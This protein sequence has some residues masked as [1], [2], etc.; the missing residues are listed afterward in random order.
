MR[1]RVRRKN[2]KQYYFVSFIVF[3]LLL[4]LGYSI[5]TTNLNIT[6]T[7]VLKDNRWDIHFENVQLKSGSVGST[8]T[9]DSN[10][11]SVS[12]SITLNKPGDFYEFTVDAVND[13]TID[14]M[15]S[16]VSSKLNGNPIT[17]LPTA[18]NYTLTYFDGVEIQNNHLLSAET[19]EIYKIRVEYRTDIEGDDL[20]DEEQ[21]LN[22]TFSANFV[23]A[24]DTAVEVQHR[25]L[26]DVLKNEALNGGLAKEYVGNHKD[27][28]NV[29]ATK[30]IYHWYADN[31]TDGIQVTNMSNVIFGGFCWQMLRTTDTGGVKLIYNGVPAN[32][33]CNN[34]GT[35]QI[36]GTSSFNSSDN[37]LY[38]VGYRYNTLASSYKEKGNSAATSGSLFG[39]GVTYSGSTYTLTDTST[40]YDDY[41]HYT[42]NNTTGTCSTVRYYHYN[43]YYIELTSGRTVEYALSEML[44]SDRTNISNSTIKRNVDSWYSS[45]LRN[46]ASQLEDT[47]FC[48]NRSVSDYGGWNPN[49]GGKSGILYFS[50]TNSV[51]LSCPRVDD[52]YSVANTHAKLNYPIGLLT[53]PEAKILNNTKILDTGSSS[54]NFWLL[55]PF[56]YYYTGPNLIYFEDG[57]YVH[58][59]TIA[60]GVRPVISLKPNSY[61]SYG[62]GS[63]NNPYYVE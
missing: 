2:K 6:G 9:I 43:N 42:C 23:Q 8:P 48:N 47:I 27:S 10:E 19:T 17:T 30:K 49:G 28:Y 25:F 15:I 60:K 20:P 51:D 46:Y 58:K 45:N 31:D 12:Y 33:Q 61:Y 55:T 14:G 40:T 24:D 22:F 39:T 3:S 1:K 52:Q 34:T 53:A 18:L 7:A 26:Y 62:D 63:K 29:T 36:T 13:G 5:L 16:S 4:F 44:T 41:H 57:L 32:G 38:L 59:D 37:G 50:D 35:G 56:W 54:A 21:T 11:T